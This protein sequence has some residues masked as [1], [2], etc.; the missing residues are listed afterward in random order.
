MSSSPIAL[1]F[2]LLALI[3]V[4]ALAWVFIRA[5]SRFSPG[6]S[7]NGR[8]QILQ[9]VPLGPRERL[10]LVRLDES[11][12]FLGVTSG[13]ISMLQKQPCKAERHATQP[14]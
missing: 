9:N 12:Y 6:T 5:L 1:L 7:R 8:V 10:I 2:T 3:L 13:G 14:D 4:L 11:E